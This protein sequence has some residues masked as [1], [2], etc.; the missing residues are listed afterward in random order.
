MTIVLSAMLVATTA[1]AYAL[2][3]VT[4][5]DGFE[6]ITNTLIDNDGVTVYKFKDGAVTCYGSY[7]KGNSNATS[8]SCVSSVAPVVNVT[9]P[10]K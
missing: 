2:Y 6:K 8:L 7:M 3:K 9:V 10:K 5:V 4:P 1:S